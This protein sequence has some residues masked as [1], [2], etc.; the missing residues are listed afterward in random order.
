MYNCL[1]DSEQVIDVVE[2]FGF[3]SKPRGVVRASEENGFISL[4]SLVDGKNVSNG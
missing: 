1:R 2:C 4:L 3:C